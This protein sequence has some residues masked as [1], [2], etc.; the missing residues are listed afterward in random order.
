MFRVFSHPMAAIA[1]ILFVVAISP[2]VISL[3]VVYV[4][5][6]TVR[7]YRA[8]QKRVASVVSLVDGRKLPRDSTSVCDAHCTETS[9]LSWSGHH[10]G[11][12]GHTPQQGLYNVFF[13]PHPS[14]PTH[15]DNHH[16]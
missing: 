6:E 4:V 12:Y 3:L 11:E 5:I 15:T 9:D 10:Q 8:G 7:T 16:A 13:L 2:V 1:T 14:Q